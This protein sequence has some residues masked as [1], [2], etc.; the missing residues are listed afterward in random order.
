MRVEGEGPR[1]ARI[2]IVGEAPGAS[3]EQ[4]GRPFVGSSG[5][6]LTEMLLKAGIDRRECYV[7]NVVKER[8]PR[9][10]FGI[11]YT[12]ARRT[13]P[14][15]MLFKAHLALQKEVEAIGAN[16]VI[17][18]GAEAL[19]ALTGKRGIEKWRGSVI[20]TDFGKVIAT[21]HPAYLLRM[22][23]GRT[24][25]DLDL[26][27][28][29]RE[30]GSKNVRNPNYLFK[31]SPNFREV[32]D[33]LRKKHT[34][35]AFD[36]ETS[37][38]HVRCLGFADSSRSAICI[39]FIAT[40]RFEP[41]TKTLFLSPSSVSNHNSYWSID[42]ERAILKEI[43]RIF[44][45]ESIEKIAQNFPFDSTILGRDFGFE[46]R[47]LWMDTMVAQ[48]CCYAELPKSLDF[49]CSIYTDTPRYS[50]YDAGS[51][52]STWTYNCYDCA[53]TFEVSLKLEAEMREMHQTE[54]YRELAQPA[55]LALARASNR[56]ILVDQVERERRRLKAETELEGIKEK[57]EALVGRKL[58][59]GSPKQM[60]EYLYK[61]L[62]LP[63]QK[64]KLRK[65]STNEEALEALRKKFPR[66]K[67][68]LDLCLEYRGLKKLIGTYL[69]CELIG[70]RM[71]CSYHATGTVTGRISS[72]KTIFGE[73]GNLQNQPRGEFR[74][75]YV[76]PKGKLLIKADLA[77]AEA[78]IVAHIA[79]IE[80]LIDNFDREDF[81]IHRWNASLIF[82]KDE[83][84]ITK[85]QRQSAKHCLHS[86]NYQGSARTAVKHAKVDY[87]TAKLALER[88]LEAIPEMR[89]WWEEIQNT[90][91]TEH[92]LETPLGRQRIFFG[93]LDQT[94][95]RSATAFI[96]Q[97]T[98]GDQINRAFFHLDRELP[99]GCFPLLQVH[100]E[101][102]IEAEE[103]K[104]DECVCII[105]RW[106]EYPIEING[107]E[108]RIPA[109]ISVG[110]NW[111]DQ[112]KVG[113]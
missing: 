81:D 110:K 80:R 12:D 44:L 38:R 31:I 88:W 112:K 27:K 22:Y 104:I 86:A 85:E 74:R 15:Q 51:D 90:V 30:S 76:A 94:T 101:I 89:L 61:E 93:R 36:I 29:K 19:Y 66:H 62:R 87:K 100:D 108:V 45:D 4:Q 69:N 56:G 1:T 109:D 11:Y 107:R 3:E 34:R 102:V 99:E 63:E 5:H 67:Q 83:G 39:P 23:T 8:P 32:M 70:G 25:V 2:V 46:I 24:I 10:N 57:I 60:K 79:G 105:R 48:H 106:L 64:T 111:F 75:I 49:L 53:V 72:S 54:F 77:Q 47:G 95:F 58:N 97:S 96:P 55:M 73:G 21:Y 9:N 65:V 52:L 92:R 59:P 18:L 14:S 50:D 7:T 68:I 13:Q 20:G 17:A 82:G 40:K 42:E 26:K 37:G 33:F 35:L 28:A 84:E 6:L 78:R 113:E 71:R 91:V 41:E 103:E 43:D 98:I 16:V